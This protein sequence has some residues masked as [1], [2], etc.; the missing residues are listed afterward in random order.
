MIHQ[1]PPLFCSIS[2]LLWRVISQWVPGAQGCKASY[3]FILLLL[4]LLLIIVFHDFVF[5]SKLG[6]VDKSI[7]KC[8]TYIAFKKICIFPLYFNA[9]LNFFTFLKAQLFRII[10]LLTQRTQY[11]F[12]PPR[13]FSPKFFSMWTLHCNKT[14]FCSIDSCLFNR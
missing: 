5:L 1:I 12:L 10:M 14:F 2:G 4:A 13:K 8:W 11:W 7:S 9:F 3:S 6:N